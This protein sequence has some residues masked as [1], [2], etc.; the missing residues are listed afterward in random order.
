MSQTIPPRAAIDYPS[1]DGKPLAENDPQLHAIHNESMQVVFAD[2]IEVRR[3]RGSDQRSV[4]RNQALNTKAEGCAHD[5]FR[6]T[7]EVEVA[8]QT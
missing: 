3:I 5:R 8:T 4:I 6:R 2:E 7:P 1:G